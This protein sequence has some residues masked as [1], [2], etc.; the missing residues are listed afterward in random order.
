MM[1]RFFRPSM[2]IALSVAVVLVAVVVVFQG[3]PAQGRPT[4]VPVR[5]GEREVAWLYPA[6]GAPS[7]QRFVEA[8]RRSA[9]RLQR[10]GADIAADDRNA[11][12][13]ETTTVPEVA[14]SSGEGGPRFVFRWY[15]LTSDWK[16]NDWIEALIQRQPPPLAI[17]G[18]SNS[19][20]ARELATSLRLAADSLPNAER[21]LLFLTTATADRVASSDEGERGSGESTSR[22]S[23][24]LTQVYP[25]RTFRFCFS[26]G[27]MAA[28]VSNFIWSR[29]DLRPQRDPYYAA[30]WRDDSYSRDF[31]EGFDSA[32]RQVIARDSTNLWAWASN[33]ALL[34]SWPPFAGGIFPVQRLRGNPY[35]SQTASDFRLDIPPN[36]LS[37]ASSVGSFDTPNPYEAKAAEEM[38]DHWSAFPQNRPLLILTGQS[39]PLR[40][41]LRG[42]LRGVPSL[43]KRVEF[44][45]ATGDAISF[46]TVYRDRRDAWNIL[47][48]PFSLVFFCHR[49]P[50]SPE[51]GFRAEGQRIDGD[52]QN[53]T[54]ETG[55]EDVL[56]F[57]DIVEALMQSAAPADSPPCAHAEELAERLHEVRWR[58]GRTVRDGESAPLFDREGQRRGG[59]GEHV[60]C[61]KPMWDTNYPDRLLPRATI[62]VWAWP[63]V[64]GRQGER[65]Q[66]W[67]RRGEPLTVSYND[68]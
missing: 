48:L 3:P 7:W 47:D 22:P 36:K 19:E 65:G 45:V 30:T 50:I 14:L 60:V 66:R 28:A 67:L 12:P 49:D 57:G 27:Q 10:E 21:P 9:V 44:V 13:S 5:A 35:F 63:R 38:L 16:T 29:D 2:A 54:A 52:E 23:V 17:V 62:E 33:Q 46:N 11:F 34:R 24:Q 40:R 41:F 59:T 4:P 8:V 20:S 37:I 31:V 55:T 1:Q 39:Q 15:K 42:V 25:Q 32:L 61:L 6:T 26:N 53:N 43:S 68:P 58:D 51:A 18:G 64:E 56:L